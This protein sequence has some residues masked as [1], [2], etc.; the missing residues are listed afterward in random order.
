MVMENLK[1]KSP[2][3]WMICISIEHLLIYEHEKKT[4]MGTEMHIEMAS[5][6]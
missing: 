1:R 5:V 3:D 6:M 4:T 2:T